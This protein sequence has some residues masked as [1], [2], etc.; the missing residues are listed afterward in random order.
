MRRLP[1]PRDP[2]FATK[3]VPVTVDQV[4]IAADGIDWNAVDLEAMGNL[5]ATENGK[6]TV[7]TKIG[8]SSLHKHEDEDDGIDCAANARSI[9]FR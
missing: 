6:S 3:P 2:R 7:P 8:V 4:G 9:Y 5:E 1:Y